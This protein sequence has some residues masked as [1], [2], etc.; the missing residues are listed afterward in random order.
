M[1]REH[2][3]KMF[4]SITCG[5]MLFGVFMK[6]LKGGNFWMANLLIGIILGFF[7]PTYIILNNAQIKTYQKNVIIKVKSEITSLLRQIYE[8]VTN[9]NVFKPSNQ[10]EPIE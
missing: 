1:K 10:I 5:M 8:Q 3:P 7:L 4:V 2:F 6:F 9:F